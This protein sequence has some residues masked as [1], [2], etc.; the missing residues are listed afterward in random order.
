MEQNKKLKETIIQTLIKLTFQN[1]EL[2]I[3]NAKLK[4]ENLELKNQK[5]KLISLLNIER[6]Q[7]H[8]KS[9]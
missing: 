3:E 8:K 5:E 9:K 4:R 6:H 2:I 7:N 1:A